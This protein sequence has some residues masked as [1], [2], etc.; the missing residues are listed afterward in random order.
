MIARLSPLRWAILPLSL[1]GI[2]GS[3]WPF[4]FHTEQ[5]SSLSFWLLSGEMDGRETKEFAL[6]KV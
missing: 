2:Q 5:L 4:P 6:Y 3:H 1:L